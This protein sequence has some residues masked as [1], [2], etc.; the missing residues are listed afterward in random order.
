MLFAII[1]TVFSTLYRLPSYT[2][3]NSLGAEYPGLRS[4]NITYAKYT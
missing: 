2:S 1:I 4:S 3:E